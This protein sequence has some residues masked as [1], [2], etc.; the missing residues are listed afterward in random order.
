MVVDADRKQSRGD[1]ELETKQE[2]C[3][4]KAALVGQTEVDRFLISLVSS[5]HKSAPRHL[6]SKERNIYGVSLPKFSFHVLSF[7]DTPVVANVY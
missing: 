4:D 5:F 3:K 1:D 2:T 7:R 6:L